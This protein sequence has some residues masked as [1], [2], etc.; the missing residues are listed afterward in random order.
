MLEKLLL[1]PREAAYR[2]GGISLRHLWNLTQP[3]GPLPVVRMGRRVFYRPGDLVAFIEAA[4]QQSATTHD[5][6]GSADA[7]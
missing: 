6:K 3:R 1:T 7:Q 5:A 2:L 4:A